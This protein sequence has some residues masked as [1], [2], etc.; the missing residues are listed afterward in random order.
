MTWI[1]VSREPGPTG[2]SWRIVCDT[3]KSVIENL[4][5]QRAR[6]REVLVEDANGRRV[7][8]NNFK[9]PNG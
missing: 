2:Q 9:H 6:G 5:D 1:V 7:D 8:E 3:P 4:A